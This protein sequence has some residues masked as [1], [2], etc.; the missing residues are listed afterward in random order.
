V[1]GVRVVQDLRSVAGEVRR[2]RDAGESD[3]IA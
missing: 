1:P 3:R 2:W